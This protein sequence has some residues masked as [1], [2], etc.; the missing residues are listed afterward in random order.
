MVLLCKLIESDLYFVLGRRLFEAQLLVI[1][2]I[3]V[4][5]LG[6]RKASD[7]WLP[8]LLEN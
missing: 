7:H 4:E 8:C 6:G 5:L 2:D 1:V 3:L